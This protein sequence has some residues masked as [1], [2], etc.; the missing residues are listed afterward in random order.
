[1]S[2]YISLNNNTLHLYNGDALKLYDEWKSPTVIISDGPYGV[3]GFP[4]DLVTPDG[5]AEWY[6]PHIKNGANALHH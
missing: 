5:L 1:M 3:N 6:E 4:G 2:E